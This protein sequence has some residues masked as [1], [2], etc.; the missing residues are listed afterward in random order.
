LVCGDDL[1]VH[2]AAHAETS[3][4]VRG[5]DLTLEAKLPY[6]A[7]EDHAEGLALLAGAAGARLLVVYDS[8]S[9]QRRPTSESVLAD[10]VR[11]GR[12]AGW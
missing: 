4:V 8:P 6:G 3:L 11:I 2:R 9:P 10:R 12:P 7:G 1:L 5:A